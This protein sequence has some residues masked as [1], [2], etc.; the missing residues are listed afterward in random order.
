ME[1]KYP[2]YPIGY[3]YR[4]RFYKEGDSK[5]R[6]KKSECESHDNKCELLSEETRLA[7]KNILDTLAV[8]GSARK[9]LEAARELGE[10][11]DLNHHTTKQRMARVLEWYENKLKSLVHDRLSLGFTSE[12]EE[13]MELLGQGIDFTDTA[14]KAYADC[15]RLKINRCAEQIKKAF[16]DID[17]E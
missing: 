13:L 17:F 15:I 9:L 3:P 11:L 14:K 1:Y 12:A 8:T 16:P 5:K 6:K 10:P 4:D 2:D 7:A